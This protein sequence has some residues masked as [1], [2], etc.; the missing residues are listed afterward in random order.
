MIRTMLTY[1]LYL[2]GQ[3]R[4]SVRS[5]FK[6]NPAT[7]EELFL[8]LEQSTLVHRRVAFRIGSRA[9]TAGRPLGFLGWDL[10]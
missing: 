7:E 4:A 6:Q 3:C 8:S 10:D 2:G 1:Y 5:D 9:L